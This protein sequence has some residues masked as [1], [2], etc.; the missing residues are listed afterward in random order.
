MKQMLKL[1]TLPL[2]AAT[3]WLANGLPQSPTGASCVAPGQVHKLYYYILLASLG[4]VL[5]ISGTV[6]AAGEVLTRSAFTIAGGQA[7]VNGIEARSAVGQPIAGIISNNGEVCVGFVCP[8]SGSTQGVPPITPSPTVTG[9]VTPEASTT[10]GS[11]T[12][13]SST[14]TPGATTTPTTPTP[15]ATPPPSGSGSNIYLPVVSR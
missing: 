13:P 3:H 4:L 9:S 1:V 8:G 15:G 5:L 7:V 12:T 11:T 10:P 2:Q 6:L 14:T